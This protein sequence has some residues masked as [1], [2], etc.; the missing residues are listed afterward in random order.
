MHFL[1]RCCMIYEGYERMPRLNPDTE[2]L[3]RAAGLA[4]NSAVPFRF[5][6][7]MY[8][9]LEKGRTGRQVQRAHTR[10][11]KARKDWPRLG[12]PCTRAA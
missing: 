10:I 4:K 2:S 1:W 9:A 6:I 5:L 11:A 8:L 3:L 12:H 7:G